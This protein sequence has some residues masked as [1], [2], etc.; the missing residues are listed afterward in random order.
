MIKS[1]MTFTPGRP[2]VTPL[3]SGLSKKLV[4]MIVKHLLDE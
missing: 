3:L 4:W 2:E 1:F